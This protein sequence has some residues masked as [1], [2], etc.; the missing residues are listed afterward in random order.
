MHVRSMY[1][2]LGASGKLNAVQHVVH[3]IICTGL[4]GG[5]ASTLNTDQEVFAVGLIA[6]KKKKEE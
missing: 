3:D 5:P 6:K 4:T 1:H 2:Y